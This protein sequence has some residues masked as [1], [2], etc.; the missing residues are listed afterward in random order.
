M[1]AGRGEKSA[2]PTGGVRE[3][4]PTLPLPLTDP[5]SPHPAGPFRRPD[6]KPISFQ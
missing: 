6:E 1:Y 4:V 5:H 2:D 3:K